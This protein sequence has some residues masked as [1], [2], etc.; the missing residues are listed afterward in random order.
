MEVQRAG[1]TKVLDPP[2]PTA[3]LL[4]AKRVAINSTRTVA[5]KG[6]KTKGA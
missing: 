2:S 4:C 3:V 6:Q 5:E 1:G